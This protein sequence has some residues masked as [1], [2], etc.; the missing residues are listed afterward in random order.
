MYM[1]MVAVINSSMS[2]GM[3]MM[4][5]WKYQVRQKTSPCR[6][7]I[8]AHN[9]DWRRPIRVRWLDCIVRAMLLIHTVETRKPAKQG[10]SYFVVNMLAQHITIIKGYGKQKKV[11]ELTTK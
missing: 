5:S 7:D 3:L 1:M 9:H 2:A 8:F 6:Y 4:V 10:R 11:C